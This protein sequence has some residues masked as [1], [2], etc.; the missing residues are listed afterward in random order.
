MILW[1]ASKLKESEDTNQVYILLDCNNTAYKARFTTGILDNG[2]IFGFLRQI[3]T[4]SKRFKTN[5][6]LFCWDSRKSFRKLVYPEYKAQRKV[7]RENH[8]DEEKRLYK[9][10]LEQMSILRKDILPELG[11]VNNYMKTGYEADD[12][13][14]SISKSVNDEEI[15]IVSTDNDLLQ[16]LNENNCI[17]SDKKIIT[18]SDFEDSWGIHPKSWGDVKAIAGCSTDNVK[19]IPGVGEK[20]AVKYIQGNL[21]KS[22][23]VF[24]KIEENYDIINTNEK[25]VKLPFEGIG[26]FEIRED[27]LLEENFKSAFKNLGFR[28]FFQENSWESWVSNFKLRQHAQVALRRSERV[29]GDHKF[30]LKGKGASLHLR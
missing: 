3:L 1:K 16:L 29:C 28:S 20:T 21:K 18:K 17:M 25:L 27:S 11:F 19:G 12:I 15:V 4:L 23:K 14:A 13:I 10:L 7:S 30:Y 8:T 2:I 9:L 26:N 5:K 6:F 22:S 24:R